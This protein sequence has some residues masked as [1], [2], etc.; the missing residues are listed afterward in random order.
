MA[1]TVGLAGQAI[2]IYV[3]QTRQKEVA[4]A[5]GMKEIRLRSKRE[6]SEGQDIIN[7]ILSSTW[8]DI[9]KVSTIWESTEKRQKDE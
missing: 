7:R 4:E 8:R 3:P 2:G 1:I 6:Y 5:I 9:D